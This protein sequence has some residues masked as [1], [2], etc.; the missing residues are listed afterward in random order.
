MNSF[1]ETRKKVRGAIGLDLVLIL[2]GALIVYAL[3]YRYD[4]LE[5]F[6]RYSRAHDDWEMDEFLIVAV[7]L[8]LALGY[9]SLRRLREVVSSRGEI[10]RKNSELQTALS[11]VKELRGLL[12]ICA[13]CKSIRDDEGFWHHV[14]A[15]II[16]HSDATFTHSLCPDCMR[17]LYPEYFRGDEYPLPPEPLHLADGD[18]SEPRSNETDAAP[19]GGNRE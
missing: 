1:S 12:P 18:N 14:E 19:S 4:L 9:F 8:V 15:Y 13:S 2:A 6:Y 11:E 7:Y 5:W 10:K 3:S 17:R 16:E